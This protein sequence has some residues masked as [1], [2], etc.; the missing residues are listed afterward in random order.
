MI[1]EFLNENTWIKLQA[2][3]DIPCPRTGHSAC[4]Y[5]NEYMYIFGGYSADKVLN[6]MYRYHILTKVIYIIS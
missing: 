1:E 2:E 4:S 3:G 6:D 5:K